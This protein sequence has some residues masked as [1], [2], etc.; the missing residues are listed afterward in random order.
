MNPRFKLR[1]FEPPR[2]T[3]KQVIKD[4]LDVLHIRGYKEHRLPCGKYRA[5]NAGGDWQEWYPVGTPDYFMAHPERP[6]FYIEFKRPGGKLRPM[7]AF[8][9]GVLRTWRFQVAVV[10]SVEALAE[11]LKEHEQR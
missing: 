4:C 3:E 9:H 1:S 7:Q 10:D 6:G 2:P 8:R 11:F 5:A